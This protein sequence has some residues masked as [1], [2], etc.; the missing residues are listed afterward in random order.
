MPKSYYLPA[1][2]DGKD[3]W[4]TNLA[5]KFAIYAAALGFLPADVT[6]LSAD[7]AYFHW[8]LVSQGQIAAYAQQWTAYKNAVR[9]GTGTSLGVFPVPPSLGTTP[10]AVAPNVFG[11]ALLLVGRLQG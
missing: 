1:N 8:A 3:I 11:R 2:E 10:T 9:N 4:L 7:A 5:A 6:A